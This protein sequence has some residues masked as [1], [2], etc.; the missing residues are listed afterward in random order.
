MSAGKRFRA[1]SR[2]GA[3]NRWDFQIIDGVFYERSFWLVTS[4]NAVQTPPGATKNI[5]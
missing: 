5:I 3:A 1:E 2:P 4:G